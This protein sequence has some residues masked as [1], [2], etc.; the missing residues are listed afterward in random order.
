MDLKN[1]EE[2]RMLIV[3]RSRLLDVVD[4]CEE[5]KNGHFEFTEHYGNHPDRISL[6]DLPDL[7]YKIKLS[8][9]EEIKKIEMKLK[10]L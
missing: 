1:I 7:H 2:A 3:Q 8:I 9:Q 10:E 4:K 5:W 6:P